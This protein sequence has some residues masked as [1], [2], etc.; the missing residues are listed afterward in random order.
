MSWHETSKLST[1]LEIR[2][3]GINSYTIQII[4]NKITQTVDFNN[5][6]EKIEH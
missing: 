3:L 4:I 2:Q 1:Y 5:W 6:W